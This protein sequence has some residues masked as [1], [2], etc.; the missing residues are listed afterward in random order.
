[1]AG[2]HRLDVPPAR[3]QRL[4]LPDKVVADE[5]TTAYIHI[6]P[7]NTNIAYS[8]KLFGKYKF[9]IGNI[10]QFGFLNTIMP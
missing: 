6:T 1:V 3:Q 7:T 2:K 4:S 10:Y 5:P 8:Y 9:Y